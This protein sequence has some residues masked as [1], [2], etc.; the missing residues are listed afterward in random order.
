[1][2]DSCEEAGAGAWE[3]LGHYVD[4]RLMTATLRYLVELTVNDSSSQQR[5]YSSLKHLS[6]TYN[7]TRY[8]KNR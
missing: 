5:H 1:M 8:L 7:I 3:D 2:G 6:T 4:M